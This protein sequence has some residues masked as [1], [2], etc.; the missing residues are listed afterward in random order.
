MRRKIVGPRQWL[1]FALF[2]LRWWPRFGMHTLKKNKAY[3]RGLEHRSILQL[4]QQFVAED[5]HPLLFAPCVDRV[6]NHLAAGDKIVLLSGTLDVLAA[7]IAHTVGV[8]HAVGTKCTVESGR[9]TKDPPLLHP[10]G[11]TK[12]EIANRLSHEFEISLDDTVALADSHWD[13]PLLEM[14]G[15][16]IAVRPDSALE[17]AARKHHW[18]VIRPEQRWLKWPGSD[19][20]VYKRRDSG[21]L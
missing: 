7:A 1:A 10:F 14:V 11:I 3:L 4:A 17:R 15:T 16:A 19:Q 12:K 2:T 9:Y 5:I 21:S 6:R 20:G 18:E 13:L 8:D